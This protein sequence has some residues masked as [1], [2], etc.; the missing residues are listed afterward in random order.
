MRLT[1]LI[2]LISER[3][4]SSERT[5]SIDT[6]LHRE[7]GVDLALHEEMLSATDFHSLP[8]L[9]RSSNRLCM[10]QSSLTSEM[11]EARL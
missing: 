11:A 5:C 2:Q 6:F 10:L 9:T 3:Q 1:P 7:E 8:D 4:Q